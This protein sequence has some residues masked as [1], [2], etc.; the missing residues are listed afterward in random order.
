M[1]IRT[2]ARKAAWATL[3]AG[4]VVQ[5]TFLIGDTRWQ[6]IAS[7]LL[8]AVTSALHALSTGGWRLAGAILGGIACISFI[9]EALGVA[10]GFPFGEYTYTGGLG[11]SLLGVSLIVPLA[12]TTLAYPAWVV[13]VRL[14][15]HSTGWRQLIRLGVGAWA[16]TAW[17]VFLD[18][19]MVAAGNWG[20][21]NPEP[22]LLG[23]PG[24]PLTNYAGWL[25]ISFVIMLFIDVAYRSLR[26]LPESAQP[27]EIGTSNT[28]RRDAVVYSVYFWTFVSSL[29]GNLTFWQRPSVALAG[30][31]AMGIV[32]VPLGFILIQSRSQRNNGPQPQKIAHNL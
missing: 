18:S 4:I 3:A 29:I 10:T 2:A 17:D 31:I 15:G 28:Q 12:W 20:W 25:L 21:A 23:T 26:H 11:P 24:I 7:V 8:F 1:N 27:A 19:Q 14:V 16:L 30:S 13:A 22:S 9:A 5:S 32:V 6:T